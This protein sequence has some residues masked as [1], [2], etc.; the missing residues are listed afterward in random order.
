PADPPRLRDARRDG[1]P[2]PARGPGRAARGGGA[3][4]A[5]RG[6]GDAPRLSRPSPGRERADDTPLRRADRAR[7]PGG[8]RVT[9]RRVRPSLGTIVLAIAVPVIFLH[10]RYQPKVHVALGSTSAGIELSDLA[11][12]AVALAAL[13]RG[14][15]D[16]FGRLREARAVWIAA[17][18][19]L[20]MVAAA[21]VYPL[22]RAADYHFLTHTVTTAQFVEYAVLA[23]AVPLL[24][25]P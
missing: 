25:R 15:R 10:V 7:A 21:T 16:G 14:L 13:R 9:W 22:A 4:P 11:V 19:F 24:F 6:A 12:L 1:A 3:G 8:R 5:R 2:R 23:L 18:L 17:A 20:A